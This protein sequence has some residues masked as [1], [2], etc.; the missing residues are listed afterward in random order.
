MIETVP[1]GIE[2]TGERAYFCV[3]QEAAGTTGTIVVE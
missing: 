1:S 3:P 2:T